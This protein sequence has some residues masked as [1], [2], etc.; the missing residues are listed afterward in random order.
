MCKILF[1]TFVVPIFAKKAMLT[2][3]RLLQIN[4]LFKEKEWE[5][6][7]GYD[8]TS[9]LNLFSNRLDKIDQ[10]EQELVLDLTKRFIFIREENIV[11]EIRTS[12]YCV[13][14]SI[15]KNAQH[16]YIAPLKPLYKK[17]KNGNKK[18]IKIKKSGD[19]MYALFSKYGYDWMDYHDK[20][21]MTDSIYKVNSIEEN[22][23]VI[24]LDDFIGS[25]DTASTAVEQI[26]EKTPIKRTQ[27]VITCIIAHQKGIDRLATE[28]IEL[29]SSTQIN[30]GISDFYS[31]FERKKSI[32]IAAQEKISKSKAMKQ[33]SLGY[34]NCEALVSIKLKAPNNT[35][36]FYWYPKD[37][38]PAMFPRKK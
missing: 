35:F 15:C 24:L 37:N 11:E 5:G 34:D 27:I 31:D 23:I 8:N 19:L 17:D 28:N 10:H 6:L 3:D 33:Y 4:E 20:F 13:K 7:I 26:L 29:F 32:I 18:E 12:Y 21:I 2:P 25:G 38:C 36:P 1:L 14:D 30:R 16:I 22:D 9:L